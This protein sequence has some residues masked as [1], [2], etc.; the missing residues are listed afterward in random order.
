MY[1][2]NINVNINTATV[3]NICSYRLYKQNMPIYQHNDHNNIQETFKK[4][5]MI[6]LFEHLFV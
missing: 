1:S 3:V 4:L 6:C 5:S 2:H